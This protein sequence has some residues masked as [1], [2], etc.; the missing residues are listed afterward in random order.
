MPPAISV[1]ERPPPLPL[2]VEG[3]GGDLAARLMRRIRDKL[4]VT[5]EVTL[6]PIGALPRSEYKSKLVDKGH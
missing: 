3:E 1:R 4:L 6:A 5:T 2:L